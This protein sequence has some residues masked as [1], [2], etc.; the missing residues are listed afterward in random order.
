MGS[1]DQPA[2]PPAPI[3]AH[4]LSGGPWP[5]LTPAPYGQEGCGL[6][7]ELGKH[8]LFP[9]AG[10]DRVLDG[11]VEV[12]CVPVQNGPAGWS[13]DRAPRQSWGV[14]PVPCGG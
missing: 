2:S 12:G 1:P 6:L 14:T 5:R 7:V 10:R 13:Q 11:G 8:F 9:E 3:S 4:W